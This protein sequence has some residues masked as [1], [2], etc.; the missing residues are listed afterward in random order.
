[1]EQKKRQIGDNVYL[2]TQLDAIAALKIQTK[3]IKLLGPSVLSLVGSKGDVKDKIAKIVPAILE[4]FDDELANGLVLAL[5]ERNVFVEK[6]G[7]Q[8]SVDFATHFCGKFAEMWKVVPFI[9]EVNFS[10]GELFG[11]SSHTTEEDKSKP[12]S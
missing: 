8:E 11:S 7:T 2:V 9:L 10:M 1:M 4:N 6:N 12:E 3:L 5:F